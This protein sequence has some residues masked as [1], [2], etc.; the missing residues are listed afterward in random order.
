MYKNLQICFENAQFQK[1]FIAT[2]KLLF[3]HT[4]LYF[5]NFIT[6]N[7]SLWVLNFYMQKSSV[8]K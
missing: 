2:A 1:Q 4:Y 5:T 3:K 6:N 8:L 7:W